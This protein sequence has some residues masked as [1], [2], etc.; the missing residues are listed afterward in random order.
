[1]FRKT[2][3][4]PIEAALIAGMCS[5][6]SKALA[7]R[8]ALGLDAASR[9]EETYGVILPKR[10]DTPPTLPMGVSAPPGRSHA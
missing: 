10:T 4:D 9:A 2:V 7:D 5:S 6:L 1:M 8:R 3:S